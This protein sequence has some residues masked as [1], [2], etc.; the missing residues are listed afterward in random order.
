MH[1]R[2]NV[3]TKTVGKSRDDRKSCAGGGSTLPKAHRKKATGVANE[4]KEC[5][6]ENDM[7]YGGDGD[8]DYD[9]DYDDDDDNH[10]DDEDDDDDDNDEDDDEEDVDE[11]DDDCA[12]GGGCVE[13]QTNGSA[14]A[15]AADHCASSNRRLHKNRRRGNRIA[16]RGGSGGRRRRSDKAASKANTVADENQELRTDGIAAK[17]TSGEVSGGGS[18][19]PIGASLVPGELNRDGG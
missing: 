2:A 3:L 9:Y 15:A 18:D 16:T 11:G 19:K 13:E 1:I 12:D 10:Y 8:D 14:A 4:P 17:A 6:S 5:F 7:C